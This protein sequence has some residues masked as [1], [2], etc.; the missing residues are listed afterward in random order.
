MSEATLGGR[1]TGVAA[2]RRRATT[3]PGRLRLLSILIAAASI[4]VTVIGAGALVAAEVTVVGVHQRTVPAILGMQRIHAWLSDADRSAANAYLAGGSDVTL[5][6]LQFQADV[7]AASRELQIASEHNPGGADASRRLQTIAALVDQ[8]IELVQTAS[9][10]DRLGVPAGIVYLQA[11]ASLMHRPGT[12]ILA[13]VDALRGLYAGS[14]DGANRTLRIT[15]WLLAV[16]GAVALALLGLLVY[17]QRFVRRRFHRR[18]NP[19]LLA[20]TLLLVVVATAGGLGAARAAQ[21]VRAAED[22][23][24]ARVLNLWNARALAYDAN[25]NESLWLI[26]RETAAGA[27]FDRAFQTETR[28]LVDRP[29]TDQLVRE[30]DGGQVR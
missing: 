3:T 24:Y 27:A 12:G 26:T 29:L 1:Q 21:S 22:Q 20:A 19:R 16:Y 5:P 13:Q 18:R 8:Y 10:E 30:A 17:P 25:G 6:E 7:A 14:L 28:Q 4:A 23:S 15:A 9:V 2:G 11:G